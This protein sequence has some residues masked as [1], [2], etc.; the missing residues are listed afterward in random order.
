MPDLHQIVNF[1]PLADDRRAYSG[2]VYRGPSAYLHVVF[3]NYRSG[4]PYLKPGIVRPLRISESVAAD[5]DVVL[6]DHPVAEFA[7]F[8]NDAVRVDQ[9]AGAYPSALIDHAMRQYRNVVSDD[10]VVSDH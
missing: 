1:R 7:P 4:L 3:D 6:Q 5:H 9:D 8:A 10:H 2:A